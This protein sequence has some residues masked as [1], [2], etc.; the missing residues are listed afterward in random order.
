MFIEEK[1]KEYLASV[2][3]KER[4]MIFSVT[5][6]RDSISD[7][8]I[9]EPLDRIVNDEVKHY[10]YMAELF[11]VFLLKGGVEKRKF[12]RQ[13]S[14]GDAWLRDLKSK[15]EFK[16]RCVNFSEKGMCIECDKPLEIG[17]SYEVGIDFYDGSD[18]IRH[19]GRL[20]WY[21]EVITRLNIGGIEFKV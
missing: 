9:I 21:K 20:V 18:P 6:I 4:D 8:D 5:D 2:L 11:E 10:S 7:K 13:H 17:R 3:E 15:E 1:Y 16:A 19:V 12:R 14:L